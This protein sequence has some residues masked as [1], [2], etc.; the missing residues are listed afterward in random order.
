MCQ[1]LALKLYQRTNIV[2]LLKRSVIQKSG[3]PLSE[4][5]EVPKDHVEGSLA[6]GSWLECQ[7]SMALHGRLTEKQKSQLRKMQVEM[8]SEEANWKSHFRALKLFTELEGHATVPLS[9]PG[10]E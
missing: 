3:L 8:D 2:V 1:L 10:N 4:I 7:R 5:I 6:L 9:F